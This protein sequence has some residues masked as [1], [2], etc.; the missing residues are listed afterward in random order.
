VLANSFQHIAKLLDPRETRRSS[1]AFSLASDG[2]THYGKSYLDN[3]IRIHRDGKLY[4]LHL[5]AVPMY[6]KHTGE[7]MFNLISRILDIVCRRW[8]S[9][10]I[11][12][13]ADGASSMTGKFQGVVTRLNEV[14]TNPK[15]YRIWCGLHQLD[16]V[17]KRAY[18]GLRDNEVV[19]ILKKFIA[20]LRQQQ[21][22]INDMRVEC[23]Q[24]TTHWL[25]MG[26]VCEW[27]LA[28]QDPLFNYMDTAASEG[29]PVTTAPRSWWWV[30]IAGI[31]ALTDIINPVFKQLQSPTLLVSTQRAILN[32]L[33]VNISKMLGISL[34]GD[35]E[36]DLI[37]EPSCIVYGERCVDYKIVFAFLQDLGMHTRHTL[38]TLDEL[39]RG[40]VIESIAI[41]FLLSMDITQPASNTLYPTNPSQSPSAVSVNSDV[42][43][44]PC[45]FAGLARYW[46]AVVLSA[47]YPAHS[48]Q[49]RDDF[50]PS[51]DL[52]HSL[53]CSIIS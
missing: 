27:M 50:L 31:S 9:Q 15:F 33:A 35:A 22:L 41:Y 43:E 11:G 30:V 2:S 17:L 21:T 25:C 46:L 37:L 4:N 6:G 10:L 38:A 28:H 39:A 14:S 42:T 5:V 3:R 23:P 47:A 16:L 7:N 44:F 48:N 13:A 24:L 20:H 45:S 26:D 12:V 8:R 53:D 49:S 29:D 34:I 32:T 19:D 40:K 18:K 1:W 51:R 52:S 36:L